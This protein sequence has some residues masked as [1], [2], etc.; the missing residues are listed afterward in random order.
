[1]E[2]IIF[3]VGSGNQG[4][5][6]ETPTSPYLPDYC[7]GRCILGIDPLGIFFQGPRSFRSRNIY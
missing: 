6:I 4:I 7:P 1:M 2:P 5:G 3:R